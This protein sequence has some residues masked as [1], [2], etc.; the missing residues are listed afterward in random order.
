M[1]YRH[2]LGYTVETSGYVQHR[3][4]KLQAPSR[5]GKCS[6]TLSFISMLCNVLAGNRTR[7]QAKVD[8]DTGMSSGSTLLCANVSTEIMS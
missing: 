8:F 5:L 2:S 1:S 4:V 7:T 3:F 6:G